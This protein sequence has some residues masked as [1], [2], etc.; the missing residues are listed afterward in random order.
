MSKPLKNKYFFDLLPKLLFL[1]S[2]VIM[3]FGYGYLAKT[4]H[5]FPYYQVE[6]AKLVAQKL[7]NEKKNIR[8]WYYQRTVQTRFV[9]ILDRDKVQPG[10]TLLTC[11]GNDDSLYIKV[12]DPDGQIIHQWRLNWFKVWP[13]AKHIPARLVPKS[14]P[15]T[16]IHGVKL[17][18]NGDIIF[19][20]TELGLLRM[21]VC[22]HV[23]WRLPYC[24]HHSVN[25]DQDG[26][27]WVPGNIYHESKPKPGFPYLK[28]WFIEPMLL[29]VSPDGER[30]REISVLDILR[31]DDLTGLLV[32]SSQARWDVYARNDILHLNDLEIFPSDLP[33]GV[34]KHGDMMISLRNIQTIMVLDPVT[35]KVRYIKTGGMIRQH[36]PDFIDGNTI[37]IFDNNNVK[38]DP[39]PPYS[40]II[41]LDARTGENT[42]YYRGNTE[43]PFF[44]PI[45]GTHQW[46][47]NGNVLITETIT[48]RV[49]EIAPGGETV[50]EYFNLLN[51]GYVGIVEGAERL[52]A[53]YDRAFFQRRVQ[54]CRDSA[55]K[56]GN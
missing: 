17:F 5:W 24:T 11:V 36:D 25:M 46:L 52:P 8:P 34:F 9:P 26:F 31:E 54:A 19:N 30:V 28:P 16:H 10:A 33:E 29:K 43:H 4:F 1:L 41:L 27:L 38:N 21:D 47:P 3:S 12:V 37:S 42:V 14:R 32:M 7:I 51:D 20:F 22:G 6:N 15:G 39:D 50:W 35:L 13:H 44:T 2:L 23:I 48:G 49:F 18:P 56:D 55:S 53:E 40:R 45:M